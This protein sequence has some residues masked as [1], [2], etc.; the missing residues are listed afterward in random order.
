[1]IHRVLNKI[2]LLLGKTDYKIDKEINAFALFKIIFSKS[3]QFIRSIPLYF[4]INKAE[5][6]IFLG[7]KVNIKFKNK[8]TL[9]KTSFIGDYVEINCLSKNG[10]VVGNNF[11]IHKNSTIECYGVMNEIGEGISI[12]NNVG[13]SSGCFISVRGEVVIGD[14]VI[15]G[16]GVKIFS[17]NHNFGDSDKTINNQGTSRKGVTIKSGCWIGANAIILD[18]VSIGANS[19]VAAGSIV[20]HD[21]HSDIIVGGIPAKKI[22]DI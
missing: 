18:G 1:M 20:T 21:V 12:G 2:L 7:K 13:I 22:K 3:I 8:L 15:F 16:P 11:S 14:N 19:V 6:I 9:G 17:E 10:V 4:L 5:G